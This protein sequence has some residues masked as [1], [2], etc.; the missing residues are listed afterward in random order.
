MS[1]SETL[2][3]NRE[4]AE[5]LHRY[6]IDALRG[7]KFRTYPGN[8]LRHAYGVRDCMKRSKFYD[9]AQ[10]ITREIGIFCEVNKEELAQARMKKR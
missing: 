9:L 1:I 2:V 10:D 5:D 6:C 8:M 7:K 4:W 3:V